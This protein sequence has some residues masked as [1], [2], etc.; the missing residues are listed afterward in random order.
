MGAGAVGLKDDQVALI[1]K[2]N[3]TDDS[4]DRPGPRVVGIM[5]RH[6]ANDVFAGSM[7]LSRPAAARRG[8]PARWHTRASRSGFSELYVRAARLFDELQV[9]H[10]DGSFARRLAAM[11]KLDLLVIDDFAISPMGRPSATTCS[12][13]WTTASARAR[14]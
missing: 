6:L 10:G 13:C 2:A 12:N 5:N 4:N 7:S 14:R 8:W 9:V 3:I 11:A 1:A